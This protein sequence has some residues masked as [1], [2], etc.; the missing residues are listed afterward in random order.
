MGATI[1]TTKGFSYL[2]ALLFTVV[3]LLCFGA[4]E[5]LLR[6][7]V[8]DP[9]AAYIRTPGWGMQVRTNGLLPHVTDDHLL[10]VNRFG[11]RGELPT[12]GAAPRIAVIGGS[13]AEDWVLPEN[14]T[15]AQQLAAQLRG[16]APDVWVA[17]LGK[18][19]VNARLHLIQLPETERYMPR[20]DMLVVLL[21]L[22]DFLFDLRIHH[23]FVIPD[24]WARRQA[25]MY[26]RSEEGSLAVVA[27]ARRLYRKYVA[28][29]KNPGG[30]SDFG[31]YQK[32]LRD[33]HEKV[34]NTQWVNVMPDL[35]Q[36][37]ETYRK[38]IS[39]LKAYAD[40]YGVPILFVTQPYVWSSNMDVETKAQ[41]YAGFIGADMNSPDTKWYTP[42]ALESGL[43]AYNQALVDKCRSDHLLCVDAA[44][45]LPHEAK[46]FYDDFHFSGVGAAKLG[47]I[48]A[49]VIK[50]QLPGCR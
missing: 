29:R 11:I 42:A 49:D 2:D 20:F 28:D 32:A 47:A 36:H 4:L 13:T 22:N 27:I 10:Q 14:G 6:A 35:S 18:G 12:L 15:W 40:G 34:A 45:K 44:K 16:C 41:I 38:T 5:W 1:R 50:P 3:I 30:A 8:F 17:N 21:G 46:Y 7:F 31:D 48:V 39:A 19:G 37:L 25:L 9:T 23:P 24:D 43:S 26:D 33:A